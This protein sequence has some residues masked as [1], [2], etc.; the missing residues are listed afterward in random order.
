MTWSQDDRRTVHSTH[1]SAPKLVSGQDMCR[2]HEYNIFNT[3]SNNNV[4]AL[5]RNE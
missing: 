1:M 4:D 2:S 3:T 5:Q